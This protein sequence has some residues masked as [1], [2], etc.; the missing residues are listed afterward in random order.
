[1][2]GLELFLTFVGAKE[3]CR[4]R[5]RAY[6]TL[7]QCKSTLID[8]FS[9]ALVCLHVPSFSCP[10]APSKCVC[11]CGL[12][13]AVEVKPDEGPSDFCKQKA[14]FRR[15]VLGKACLGIFG[16]VFCRSTA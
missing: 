8:C 3:E 10:E 16:T 9:S 6:E 12:G 1:M 11:S 14:R 15:N 2:S 4:D 13:P 5:E 7:P